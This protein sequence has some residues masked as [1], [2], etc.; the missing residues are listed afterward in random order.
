MCN[1]VCLEHI[2]LPI[3]GSVCELNEISN[4]YQKSSQ[5]YTQKGAKCL[6]QSSSFR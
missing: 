4:Q 3:S 5:N 6:A 2:H 1:T